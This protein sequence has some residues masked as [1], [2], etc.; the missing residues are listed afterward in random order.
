MV[1]AGIPAP[2]ART[3]SLEDAYGCVLAADLTAPRDLPPFPSSAMDGYAVASADIA[4]APVTLPIAGE[5]H[6]GRHPEAASGAGR[7]VA[8]PTGG[9]MPEGADCVVPFE[10]CSVRGDR[11]TI[12]VPARQGHNVRP[13]GEDL[14][15]GEVLVKAG[16]RLG[17]ADLG[18][19][20]AGGYAEVEV[21]RKPVVATFS[22]GDELVKPGKQTGP[23]Q[24]F[25]SN[26]HMLRG[27]VHKAGG[28]P[29]YAGR[30]PDDPRALIRALEEAPPADV[31]LCSGGVSA[32]RD[33]PVK[34][35]FGTGDEVCCV[36]VAVQPGRPQA[37][38]HWAGKPFFGLP[39]N[40]MATLVSFELFVRPALQLMMGLPAEL[41]YL[42][43]TL[44]TGLEA[45][46]AAVR[47]VPV[48]LERKQSGLVAR[49]TGRRRSNQL[50]A[51]AR[52]SGLA[53]V[54]AGTDLSKG[55]ICRIIS[56]REQ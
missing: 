36:Q 16:R 35:A 17:P 13:A 1:L 44:E 3:I 12:T 49:T 2:R 50:A 21:Y 22:T 29:V 48:E 53:E 18:A 7:A 26:S 42:T 56:I 54:P 45:S 41:G 34:R 33:D 32:G 31:L 47:Y 8:V 11:V 19:I 40:P 9:L 51:L 25:E 52:A 20:A 55:D 37:F 24:I 43:A 46:P 39:G 6:I 5:V 14:Q 23:A 15:R 10:K 4:E 28:D 30:V 38:G 27:L